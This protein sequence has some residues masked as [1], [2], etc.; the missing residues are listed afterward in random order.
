MLGRKCLIQMDIIIILQLHLARTDYV[1]KPRLHSSSGMYATQ[2][3]ELVLNCSVEIRVGVVFTIN[4]ILPN[5]N[6]AEQ[7]NICDL[8]MCI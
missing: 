5:G 3:E 4:W 7:V 1:N 6:L 8:H 2:D